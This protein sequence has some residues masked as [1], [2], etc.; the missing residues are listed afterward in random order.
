MLTRGSMLRKTIQNDKCTPTLTAVI[1]P[2]D[3]TEPQ[4][5]FHQQT[6]SERN[7]VHIY[8]VLLPGQKNFHCNYEI[9]PR[10]GTGI[11]H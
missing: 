1:L 10:V 6:K 7:V 8:N 4:E 9:M 3:K 11:I 5:K 2:V